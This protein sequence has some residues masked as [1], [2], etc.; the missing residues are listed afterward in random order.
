MW[1]G[2]C[3]YFFV[4]KQRPPQYL[5]LFN[6]KSS[7]NYGLLSLIAL[8]I[9]IQSCKPE[10][11]VLSNRCKNFYDNVPIV[12]GGTDNYNSFRNNRYKITIANDK[13]TITVKSEFK[14]TN[15]RIFLLN[16]AG[17]NIRSS[18]SGV[19]A[20]ITDY[21]ID[22]SGVYYVVLNTNEPS[23]YSLDICGDVASSSFINADKKSFDNQNMLTG[24]G[25]DAYNSWRNKRFTF[26]V[27]EDDSDIDFVLK[28]KTT[29]CRIFILNSAGSNIRS[30]NTSISQE[31][32]PL[33]LKKGIYS[34]VIC[35]EESKPNS[36]DLAVYS[37]I[38]V[39]QN[40]NIINSTNFTKKEGTFNPAGGTDTYQS[41]Q[42][43][44]FTFR[45]NC[46]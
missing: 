46:K 41:L 21:V 37:K 36:F 40:V 45:R 33:N 1:V 5:I 23:T 7:K 11:T 9:F 17:V 42:N 39:L 27:T 3:I 16:S 15:G 22:K 25:T 26:E 44:R 8:S 14:G 35:A 18:N 31:I 30:S 43:K 10:D 12:G 34:I 38:G 28:S 6:M 2:F 13:T 24:G 19:S 4:S 20:S 29:N 32:S